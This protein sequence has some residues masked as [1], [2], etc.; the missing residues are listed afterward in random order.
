MRMNNTFTTFELRISLLKLTANA[1]FY[2]IKLF[3]NISSRITTLPEFFG[4]RYMFFISSTDKMNVLTYT[5]ERYKFFEFLRIFVDVFLH[6]FPSFTRFI[7]NL[8]PMLIG[9]G[10]EENF[11]FL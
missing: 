6:I 7:I 9:A 3:I 8:L 11:K 10:V 1:V 5:A 4:S 2:F